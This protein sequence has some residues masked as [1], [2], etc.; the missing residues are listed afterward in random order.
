MFFKNNSKYLAL[1][2]LN[3]RGESSLLS[4]KQ[5]IPNIN[6]ESRISLRAK[7]HY[8]CLLI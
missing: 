4:A 7:N 6:P 2:N 3:L 8:L 5:F 1:Y